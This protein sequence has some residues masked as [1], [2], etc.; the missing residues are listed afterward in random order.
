MPVQELHRSGQFLQRKEIQAL[1]GPRRG[2]TS[3][4]PATRR[5]AMAEK[6]ITPVRPATVNA[7]AVAIPVDDGAAE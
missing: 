7:K 1:P 5:H 3:I 6:M 2:Y 4:L